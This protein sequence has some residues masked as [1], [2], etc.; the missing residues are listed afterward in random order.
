MT[1]ASASF[2][3]TTLADELKKLRRYGVRR[4][5]LTLPTLEAIARLLDPDSVPMSDKIRTVVN[6]GAE[7]MAELR[8]D[9]VIELLDAGRHKLRFLSERRERIEKILDVTKKRLEEL[10]DGLLDELAGRLVSI[11]QNASETTRS[12]N[13]DFQPPSNNVNVGR[14]SNRHDSLA[15]ELR[16]LARHGFD[17]LGYRLVALNALNEVAARIYPSSGTDQEKVEA[18]ITWAVANRGGGARNDP[19]SHDAQTATILE[20]IGMGK[21]RESADMGVTSLGTIPNTKTP[22]W[23]RYRRGARYYRL[24]QPILSEDQWLAETSQLATALATSVL[25]LAIDEGIMRIND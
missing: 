1:A 10:E 5:K 11:A 18:L 22:A 3:R 21:K 15:F 16:R 25:Q 2:N 4:C 19:R 12:H 9:A 23:R 7:Q 17:G 13:A 20:L 8:G 14:L 6:L 24:N